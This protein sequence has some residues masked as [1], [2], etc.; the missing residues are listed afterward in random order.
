MDTTG[1]HMV[2]VVGKDMAEKCPS[3]RQLEVEGM[4]MVGIHMVEGT[5]LEV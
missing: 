4:D 1:I 3:K 2:E 5:T